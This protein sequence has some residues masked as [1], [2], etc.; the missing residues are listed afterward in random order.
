MTGTDTPENGAAREK[1]LEELKRQ[2]REQKARID[3]AV[4]KIAERAARIAQKQQEREMREGKAGANEMVP[5]DR[6]AAAEIVAL[7]LQNRGDREDFERKL[8]LLLRGKLN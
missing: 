8:L 2:I 1:A 4:L 5:Y 6:E 7:F 3:P